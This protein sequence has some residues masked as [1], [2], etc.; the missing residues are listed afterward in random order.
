MAQV[1]HVASIQGVTEEEHE[2][3]VRYVDENLGLFEAMVERLKG[4]GPE[5]AHIDEDLPPDYE[6]KERPRTIVTARG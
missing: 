4:K 6:E 3:V 1:G 2:R 5:A